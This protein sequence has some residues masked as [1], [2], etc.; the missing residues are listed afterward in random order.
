[1]LHTAAFTMQENLD[2]FLNE[3]DVAAPEAPLTDQ[4]DQAGDSKKRKS[5]QASD[6]SSVLSASL[7]T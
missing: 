6:A 1:M 2:T 3:T 4:P 7:A 5:T